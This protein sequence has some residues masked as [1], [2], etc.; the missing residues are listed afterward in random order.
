MPQHHGVL[1]PPWRPQ[2][3]APGLV[4]APMEGVTDAPM[5][6]LMTERGGFTF[7]VSEFMRISQDVPYIRP[8]FEHVPELKN[9]SRTPSG[10]QVHFQLLGG[11]PEKLALAAFR[12]CEAGAQGVDLNFGCP[13]P[14][15]NG[16]DGGATLLKY[17]DR[18]REI[19]K[20]VRQ[21]VPA[22]LP[23]SAKL[24]LGWE[25]IDDI[26]LN[27][28]RALQG[29]ASWITIHGRTKAQGYT[30]P[31]Y[32]GPIGEV[33]RQ[34]GREI[35]II[36]NGDLWTFEDFERCRDETGCT[37]FMLGRCALAD[38]HLPSRIARALG[39][40][41]SAPALSDP[42]GLEPRDWHP[43]FKKFAEHCAPYGGGGYVVRRIKQWLGFVR[44]RR[45]L[46]WFDEIKKFQT[47]EQLFGW[48]D[49]QD[50]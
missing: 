48:L 39:I 1:P 41:L 8:Y 22:H 45:P 27:A 28:E 14:T 31:A 30:P 18:I 35:P 17:P 4:L 32:W 36:A 26:H 49:K 50:H 46:P 25:S 33:N 40:E 23:V 19:V 34:L 13:S 9:H 16:S 21:S 7:C 6:A 3:G 10:T 37:Q 15:V 44:I 42:I 2:I 11:N 29:G 20:A 38:P 43:L 12:A 47:P 24:R 5:R